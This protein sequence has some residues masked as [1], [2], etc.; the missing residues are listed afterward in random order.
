M[1]FRREA[2]YVVGGHTTNPPAESTYTGVVS[3]ESVHIYFTIAAL[4]KLGI[5]TSDCGTEFRSEHKGNT[6]VVSQALYGLQSSGSTF[7]NHLAS[8]MA[9]LNYLPYRADPNVWMCK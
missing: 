1:D 6:A 2:R 9:D 5:F 4:N 3:P 8:Y 7:C